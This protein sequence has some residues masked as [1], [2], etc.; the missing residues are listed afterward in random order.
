[1]DT[2]FLIATC[3]FCTWAVACFE[4]LLA[5]SSDGIRRTSQNGTFEVRRLSSA[6]LEFARRACFDTKLLISTPRT[7]YVVLRVLLC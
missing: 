5:N 4:A 6:S 3:A 7:A 1:M 2:L